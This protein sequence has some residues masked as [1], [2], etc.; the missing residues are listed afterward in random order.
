MSEIKARHRKEIE[1]QGETKEK[2]AEKNITRKK[3]ARIRTNKRVKGKYL[4]YNNQKV[5][6]QNLVDVKRVIKIKT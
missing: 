3:E 1:K 6:K 4:C 5:L 2:K